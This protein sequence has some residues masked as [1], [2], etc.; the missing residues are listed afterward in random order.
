MIISEFAQGTD[1]WMQER[2]GIPSASSFDKVFTMAGK[3]SAQAEAYMNTLVAEYFLGEKESIYQTDAMARGIELEAQARAAYE[4]VNEVD[5]LEVGFC[6]KD[7]ERLVGCSPDALVSYDGLLEIKC[8]KASTHV[9]YLLAGKLPSTYWNQVN[10]QIWVTGR[11]YCDFISYYP[12]LPNFEI[13]VEREQ[14]TM[15][16][17]ENEV[18][19]FIEKML[20]KRAAIKELAA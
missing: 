13:R 18:N 2:V 11:E 19:A 1:E 14:K 6:F 10:G 4:F 3:P 7:D 5:V 8:P 20:A 15:D 9:G 12:G 16:M 17:I